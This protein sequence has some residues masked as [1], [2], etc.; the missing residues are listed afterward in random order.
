M[1]APVSGSTDRAAVRTERS[2]RPSGHPDRADSGGGTQRGAAGMVPS[3]DEPVGTRGQ[4]R[5][6]RIDRRRRAGCGR[7]RWHHR[8]AAGGEALPAGG[9]ARRRGRRQRP[10]RQPGRGP[11][12]LGDRRRRHRAVRRGGRATGRRADRGVLARLA[13]AQRRLALPAARSGRTGIRGTA[14]PGRPDG[15]LR[16]AVA[17]SLHSRDARPLD[18]G[19]PGCRPGRGDPHRRAGRARGRRRPLDGRY[20]AAL[21]GRSPTR[22]HRRTAGRCRPRVDGVQPDRAAGDQ[23]AGQW[24]DPGAAGALQRRRALS[25]DVRTRPGRQQ[26]RGLVAHQ[27]PGFRPPGRAAGAGRLPR[28]ND[29]RHPGRGDRGVHTG[30]AVRRRDPRTTRRWPASRC[31]CCAAPRTGSPRSPGPG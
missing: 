27:G 5:R 3:W 31:S 2:S 15:L 9:P 25:D 23:P 8:P 19:R 10:L 24:F 1:T 16:P 28:R 17:R 13:A 21:P 7:A 20:G 18:D 4:D 14:R 12:L 11:Q 26:G 29:Q 30:G 22:F 6:F